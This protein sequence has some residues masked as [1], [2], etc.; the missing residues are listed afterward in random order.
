MD[1]VRTSVGARFGRENMIV[2][3]SC[4]GNTAMMKGLYIVGKLYYDTEKV[5][6]MEEF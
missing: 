5:V 2:T 4:L 3:I 6:L 1:C